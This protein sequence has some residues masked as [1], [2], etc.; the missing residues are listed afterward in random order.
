VFPVDDFCNNYIDK[1]Q[2]NNQIEKCHA[3]GIR[4]KALLKCERERIGEHLDTVPRKCHWKYLRLKQKRQ[5]RMKCVRIMHG[6]YYMECP[7]NFCFETDCSAINCQDTLEVFAGSDIALNPSCIEISDF[8]V[9]GKDEK[10]RKNSNKIHS[11]FLGRRV[12]HKTSVGILAGNLYFFKK[13]IFPKKF[14]N[15]TRKIERV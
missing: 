12:V 4:K 9:G 13:V 6:C 10:L 8:G 14:T 5:R 15:Q 11:W 3:R 2:D 1:E 7:L